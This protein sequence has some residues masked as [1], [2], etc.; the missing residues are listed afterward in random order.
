MQSVTSNDNQSLVGLHISIASSVWLLVWARIVWRFKSSHPVLDGQN[1]F[2]HFVGKSLHYGLLCAIA[3]MLISG[4]SMVWSAG[5]PIKVF[6][7][8]SLPSPLGVVPW[9][10]QLASQVHGFC[11]NVIVVLVLVHIS[12]AFKHLMF[13]DDDTFVRMLVTP[14]EK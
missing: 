14:K 7:W 11:A 13:N 5:L 9:L 12:G 10:N 2:T 8:F 4:P 3:L 1:R 6:S